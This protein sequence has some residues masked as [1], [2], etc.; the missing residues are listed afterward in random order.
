MVFGLGFTDCL[1]DSV[2][3]D[4]ACYTKDKIKTFFW[5]TGGLVVVGMVAV[6]F[7]STLQITVAVQDKYT[8]TLGIGA[9]PRASS[10]FLLSGTGVGGVGEVVGLEYERASP[11]RAKPR[12]A[13]EA[14]CENPNEPPGTDM[15]TPLLG[16][17]AD[18]R[19]SGAVSDLSDGSALSEGGPRSSVKAQIR[20]FTK[21][22]RSVL[23]FTIFA[24]IFTGSFFSHVNRADP[25]RGGDMSQTL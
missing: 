22:H 5:V 23:F 13:S 3:S 11:R 25:S 16:S 9:K 15:S 18:F 20:K 12:T 2:E 14:R 1:S 6:Y 4:K 10:N 17:D 7:F 8:M 24:S 21:I 19:G